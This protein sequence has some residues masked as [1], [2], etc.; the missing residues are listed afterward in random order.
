MRNWKEFENAAE[1]AYPGDQLDFFVKVDGEW[2]EVNMDYGQDKATVTNVETKEKVDLE[3][4]DFEVER[5]A[6][7]TFHQKGEE[8]IIQL[9]EAENCGIHYKYYYQSGTR[10][11]EVMTPKEFSLN[12]Y[13]PVPKQTV[14]RKNILSPMQGQI[15]SLDVKVGDEV[16]EG[17]DVCV[18]ESMKMQNNISTEAKGKIKAVHIKA[19]AIVERD[20]ML[21]EIE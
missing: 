11:V 10:K 4:D 13:M 20:E 1:G 18:I 7:I 9:E 14:H 2:F 21:I 15:V 3:L 8:G 16:E 17:Q 19:G 5:N 12:K 6:F